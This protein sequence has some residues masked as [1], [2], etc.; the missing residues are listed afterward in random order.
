MLG[1]AGTH[2]HEAGGSGIGSAS[3]RLGLA[4][5]GRACSQYN[6]GRSIFNVS[7]GRLGLAGRG[8]GF[9]DVRGSVSSA[10]ASV[11]LGLAG[12]GRSHRE[13]SSFRASA[14]KRGLRLSLLLFNL[15]SLTVFGGE[16][17]REI[18]SDQ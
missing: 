10:N 6:T 12:R 4:G 17:R 14:D 11:R 15:H 9:F 13:W 18:N 16:T 8:R 3:S 1:F 2:D 5:R 7:R